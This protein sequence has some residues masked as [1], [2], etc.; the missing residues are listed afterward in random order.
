MQRLGE[1]QHPQSCFLTL[2][3]SFW[4]SIIYR[5]GLNLKG[6]SA[7]RNPGLSAGD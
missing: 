6:S 3:G 5:V 4:E 1:F 2:A 7:D